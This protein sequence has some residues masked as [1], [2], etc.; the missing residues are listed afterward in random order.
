MPKHLCRVWVVVL[1]AIAATPSLGA[2]PAASRIIEIKNEDQA[3]RKMDRDSID[4]SI[5]SARDAARRS[6]ARQLLA[7]GKIHTSAEYVAAALVFQHGE[8]SDDIRLAHAMATIAFNLDPL[9]KGAIGLL[10][11]TWDRLL[12]RLNRP[13]WYATQFVKDGDKW[14]LY[15]VDESAAT[16]EDRKRFGGRTLSEAKALADSMNAPKVVPP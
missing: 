8:G 3:D 4:W 6:E 5:V 13:Q 2:T 14:I 1:A 9:N 7:D 15:E 12:M 16:D 10:G 11:V